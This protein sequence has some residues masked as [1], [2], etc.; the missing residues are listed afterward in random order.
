MLKPG[1]GTGVVKPEVAAG[2]KDERV[3]EH[4]VG[5][6]F[7]KPVELLLIADSIDVRVLLSVEAVLDPEGQRK[8]CPI[9][10][11]HVSAG[12]QDVPRHSTVTVELHLAWKTA[13]NPALRQLKRASQR[14]HEQHDQRDVVP[15][16][17]PPRFQDV[18]RW[19]GVCQ[20][21]QLC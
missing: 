11:G 13:E 4:Q 3:Q 16:D 5:E 20:A 8:Q 10:R 18:I 14:C 9:V 2:C 1:A 6:K 15:E 19:L 7:C 21:F 12:F 17:V